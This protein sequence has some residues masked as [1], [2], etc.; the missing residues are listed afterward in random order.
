MTWEIALGI[1][2]IVTFIISIGKII[3][4]NTKALTQLQCTID[5]L[6]DTIKKDEKQLDNIS[7]Q[8]IEHE[9]R[10]SIIEQQE[11]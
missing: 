7:N 8:V 4:N 2:S 6:R 3:S 5:S 11:G 9:T 10:I 1:A